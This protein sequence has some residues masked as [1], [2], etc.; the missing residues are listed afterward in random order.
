LAEDIFQRTKSTLGLKWSQAAFTGG[1]AVIDYRISI[2][3]AGGVF[4]VL[5]SNVVSPSYT[6]VGLTTGLYY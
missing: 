4:T 1:V 5:T 3:K 2:A 6:A